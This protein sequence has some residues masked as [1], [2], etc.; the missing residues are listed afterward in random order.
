[1]CSLR[2][3][4]ISIHTIRVKKLFQGHE[5]DQHFCVNELNEKKEVFGDLSEAIACCVVD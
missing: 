2:I 5:A 3:Y 4:F 1:M